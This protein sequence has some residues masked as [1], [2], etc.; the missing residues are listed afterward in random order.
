VKATR[1]RIQIQSPVAEFE[2]SPTGYL[3]ATLMRDG[4][5]FT[6]D[7]PGAHAGQHIT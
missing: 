6:L 2:L 4:Q 7:D 3:K 5:S 1:D